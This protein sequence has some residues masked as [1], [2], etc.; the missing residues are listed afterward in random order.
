MIYFLTLSIYGGSIVTDCPVGH[1]GGAD[2]HIRGQ[3]R[4][5]IPLRAS[6]DLNNSFQIFN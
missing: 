3:V 2:G 1:D 4:V 5:L 6:V